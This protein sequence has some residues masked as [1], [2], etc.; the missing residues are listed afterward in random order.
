VNRINEINNL[1]LKGK[2]LIQSFSG[3]GA[4]GTI[5]STFLVK[6]LKMEQAAVVH[7]DELPPVA[8]IKG[9]LIEQP[10]RIFQ[11]DNIA[12]MSCEVNIPYNT[13][14]DFIEMLVDFYI[15]SGV[16]HIVPVGG[17][18]VLQNQFEEIECYGIA[19]RQE[20]L[21]FLEEK[22]VQLLEEGIVYGTVVETLELCNTKEFDSSFALLVECDPSVASYDS[23]KKLVQNLAK[24]FE[25]EFDE[26]E[27]EDVSNIIRTRIEE[28]TRFLREEA[29]DKTR[30]SHL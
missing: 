15:K 8:I 3:S 13:V 19:N 9:G 2:P 1:D 24:I 12:L 18:P 10:I 26:E 17:L 30:E 20:T 23:T 22:G 29:M 28:S 25:F 4:I 7:A 6:A 27:F 21:T 5:L 16:S 11:N 14:T